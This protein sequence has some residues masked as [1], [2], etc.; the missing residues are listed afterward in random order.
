MCP[1]GWLFPFPGILVQGAGSPLCVLL[2]LVFFV[3]L[4]CGR[5]YLPS[6]SYIFSVTPIVVSTGSTFPDQSI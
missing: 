1:G 4:S 2:R 6:R 5:V 3:R